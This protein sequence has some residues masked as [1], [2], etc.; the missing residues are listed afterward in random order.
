MIGSKIHRFKEVG[1]TNDEAFELA[2][3]GAANG[4]VVVA[5]AQTKGRGRSGRAWKSPADK[6]IY[7]SV[8]LRPQ[9]ITNLSSLTLV[10]GIAV[11]DALKNFTKGDLKV[12]WPNDVWLNGKK[13]C[14][15]LTEKGEGFIVIG[16]GV[17]VNCERSDLSPEVSKIATSLKEEEKHVFDPE[18]VLQKICDELDNYYIMF[19]SDGFEPFVALYNSWSLINDKEVAVTFNNEVTKGVAIGI[20][21]NGALLLRTGEGVKKIIAGDVSLAHPELVEG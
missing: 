16:I 10:A 4:E 6:N 12:K 21:T 17:N 7:M 3:K 18:K 8:I 13:L 19:S 20:D 1:S 11:A 5:E 15:V 14:G 9:N 2:K